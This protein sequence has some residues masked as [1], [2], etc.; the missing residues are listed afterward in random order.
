MGYVNQ[1]TGAGMDLNT[2]TIGFARRATAYK[3]ADLLFW[4]VER[5]VAIQ[6]KGLEFQVIYGGKAHPQ[7]PDGQ[8]SH[9]QDLRGEGQSSR[10]RSRSSTSKNTTWRW[11]S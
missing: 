8:G 9:P 5:L 10:T 7:R 4:N 2:F 1:H 3:R 6:D 11:P